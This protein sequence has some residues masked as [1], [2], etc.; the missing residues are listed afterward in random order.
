MTPTQ[1]TQEVI[2]TFESVTAD[3]VGEDYLFVLLSLQTKIIKEVDS[4]EV[5]RLQTE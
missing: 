5:Q 1:A 2:K 3:L 4:M